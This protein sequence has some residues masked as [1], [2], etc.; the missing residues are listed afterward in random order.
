MF[1]NG[2][3]AIDQVSIHAVPGFINNTTFGNGVDCLRITN[4]VV[5][6]PLTLGTQ[7]M[8]GGA[9]LVSSNL[10]VL[11]TGDLTVQQ[12]VVFKLEGVL[13]VSLQGPARFLGTAYEPIVFTDDSDDAIA[14]D[15]NGD[16]PSTGTPGAWWAG[17]SF[18]PNPAYLLENVVLRYGGGGTYAAL[19]AW[20]TGVA[21]R[22]VRV[23]HSLG[24]GFRLFDPTVPPSNLVAWNCGGDG[25]HLQG[26]AFDL[27]HATSAGNGGAGIRREPSWVGTVINSNSYHNGTNL[28]GLAAGDVLHSNGGFAGSN[29]NIDA[30]PQFV[31]L[32]DGDLH[33]GPASPCLGVAEHAC[34]LMSV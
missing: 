10:S 28:L 9:F 14:G 15:S 16:G 18:A 5:N 23:E 4:A 22:S 12:G 27:L 34:G 30:D 26:G 24:T 17:G 25:I 11:A 20:H 33:R 2:G 32:I 31:V 21:L 7:S 8:P 29:G 3:R 6:A 13:Q 19:E 1:D